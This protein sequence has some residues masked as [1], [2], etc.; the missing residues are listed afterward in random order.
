MI[1]KLMT[2]RNAML[3][4]RGSV[5]ADAWSEAVRGLLLLLA[6]SAP[7]IAEELWT[8]HLGLSYSIHQQPWPAWD[9][10]LAAEDELTIPV[11]VNGKPRA[12]L[13]IPAD[14]RDDR[15]WVEARALELPRIKALVDGQ[16]VRR[17]IY[18]PGRM[19]N[20]VVS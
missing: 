15:A 5:S 14:K 16:A 12:T 19:L 1:A 3:E 4:L 8:K 7:H 10:R 6:P 20:L 13:T 11:S 9:E 17:V 18:V 2:L